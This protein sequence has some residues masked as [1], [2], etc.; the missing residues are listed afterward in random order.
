MDKKTSWI[1]TKERLPKFDRYVLVHLV[2]QPWE[3]SDDPEGVFYKVVQR[4]PG[5]K[6][7]NN[8]RDY[9]WDE[10]G[11]N[12]YFGQEVDFWME[13]PRIGRK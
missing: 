7:G 4:I 1:S 11:T 2:D 9:E 5:E 6:E 10:F 12:T 3:D 8:L 13:I